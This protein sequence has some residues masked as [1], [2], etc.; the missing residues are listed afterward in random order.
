MKK[1]K[2]QPWTD[3]EIEQLQ[4][5]YANTSTATLADE[6]GCSI[7]RINHKVA[8]LGLKKSPE[9]LE[10]PAACRLRRGDN[11]GAS[12][13]FKPGQ[14]P[15]NKGVR[16]PGWHAGNMQKTQF[17]KGQKSHNWMPLGSERFSKE[18]YLQRKMTDTGYPPH[19]WVS[20]HLL[21]W[22]EHHGDV[23]AGHAVAFKNGD[24]ADIRIDNLECVTRRELMARNSIHNL[25]E[26]LKEVITLKG[27]ITRRIT[28]G[29]RKNNRGSTQCAVRHAGRAEEQG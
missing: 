15:A 16:R 18:G 26:E 3:T 6:F 17:K 12:H 19:D 9:Y 7:D 14:V 29:N 25:P 8:R 20:V 2:R 13:R 5:R 24:K 11:V 1:H 21:L 27:A 22:R 28:N 4:A 10:S 23:P